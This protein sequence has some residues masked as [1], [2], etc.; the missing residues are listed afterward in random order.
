M[1]GMLMAGTAL[2]GV[3]VATAYYYATRPQPEQPLVPLDNQSPI[4]AVSTRLRQRAQHSQR[5]K[6]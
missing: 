5:Q 3:G 2:V 4:L 1:R 6:K